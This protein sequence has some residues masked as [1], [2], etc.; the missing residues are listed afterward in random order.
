[1]ILNLTIFQ[2]VE[3]SVI[4]AVIR[5]LVWCLSHIVTLVAQNLTAMPLTAIETQIIAFGIVPAT[6][7]KMERVQ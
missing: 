1:M 5:L 3:L 2:I 6:P 4:L 7:A